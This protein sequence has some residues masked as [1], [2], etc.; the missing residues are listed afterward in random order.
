MPNNQ[1][2]CGENHQT[3]QVIE[4]TMLMVRMLIVDGLH[5]NGD[6]NEDKGE[7]TNMYEFKTENH[8]VTHLQCTMNNRNRDGHDSETRDANSGDD[9]DMSVMTNDIIVETFF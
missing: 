7:T 3:T 6:D 9:D 1:S 5:E 8:Q 2:V 4:M